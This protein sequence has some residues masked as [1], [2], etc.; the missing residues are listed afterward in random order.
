MFKLR[1]V[2]LRIVIYLNIVREQKKKKKSLTDLKLSL[3][4]NVI[5]STFV[6]KSNNKNVG[7]I[8]KIACYNSH[9]SFV[10]SLGPN[11]HTAV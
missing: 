9:L 2:V 4:C 5:T 3:F 11:V 10:I 8:I 7:T 1:I 6:D